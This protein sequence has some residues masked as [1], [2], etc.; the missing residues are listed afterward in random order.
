[1]DASRPALTPRP[2]LAPR[3]PSP[4]QPQLPAQGPPLRVALLLGPPTMLPT[5]RPKTLLLGRL[6]ALLPGQPK[7]LLIGRLRALL[8]GRLKALLIVRAP[9]EYPCG[10]PVDLG[11]RPI[12]RYRHSPPARASAR[13]SAP[14]ASAVPWRHENPQAPH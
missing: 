7:A 5:D 6:T 1:G 9:A 14:R 8:M 3:R 4:A 13:T 10:V 12:L 2:A 11:A